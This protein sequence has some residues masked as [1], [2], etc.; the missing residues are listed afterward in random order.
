V[1][2]DELV[3]C[4]ARAD[5]PRSWLP[6]DGSASIAEE[7][8]LNSLEA[9]SPHWLLRSRAE[10]DP[11][12]KQWI[13]YVLVE[14]DHGELAAYPRK[15]SEARLHGLHSLGVGGH[16]NPVDAA[17][18]D[19]LRDTWR[20]ALWGCLRREL[21]EEFPSANE[22]TLRFLGLINEDTGPVGR[23]HLGAVFHQQLAFVPPPPEGELAGLRWIDRSALGGATWPFS[24]FESWSRLALT[25]LPRSSSQP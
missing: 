12:Y 5:L 15:G 3:L 21:A 13:P 2:P 18:S 6:H 16:I 11:D 25:L 22:G 10:H 1:K 7:D 9:V 19:S 4:T 24:R 17:D 23:V 20:S 8:L 14:N